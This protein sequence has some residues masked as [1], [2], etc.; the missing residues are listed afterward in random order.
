MIAA[1]VCGRK[2]GNGEEGEGKRRGGEVDAPPL[3]VGSGSTPLHKLGYSGRVWFETEFKTELPGH[4]FFLIN[5]G[6]KPRSAGLK[7]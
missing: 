1:R 2:R 6:F 3:S 5:F 7:L 4:F